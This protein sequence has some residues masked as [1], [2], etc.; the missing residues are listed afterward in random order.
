MIIIN[1]RHD[2][3]KY[4]ERNRQE[5]KKRLAGVK[6]DWNPKHLQKKMGSQ[7]AESKRQEMRDAILKRIGEK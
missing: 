3:T 1:I 5:N 2:R 7:E 6:H 4:Y